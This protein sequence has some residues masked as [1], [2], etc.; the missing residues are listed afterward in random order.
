MRLRHLI[1]CSLVLVFGGLW[2]GTAFAA[3]APQIQTLH[4]DD[5]IPDPYAN[6]GFAVQDH[7]VGTVRM[8]SFPDGRTRVT[9]NLHVTST[10]LQTGRSVDWFISLAFTTTEIEKAR[11]DETRILRLTSTFTGLNFRFSLPGSPSISAGRGEISSV[12]VFDADGN[13]IDFKA[14][15]ISTPHI[16]HFSDTICGVMFGTGNSI[17]GTIRDERTH[18][19]LPNIC[20]VV[21][22]SSGAPVGF[23]ISGSDGSYSA[24]GETTPLAGSYKLE[25]S[26]C[27]LR[28]I[29]LHEWYRDKA[30]SASADPVR[31]V[32][33]SDTR[34]IDANLARGGTISGTVVDAATG[35]PVFDLCVEI[36]D[37]A[38]FFYGG[39]L[40]ASDGSYTAGG[41]LRSGSYRVLFADC[42]RF[43]PAYQFEWYKDKP[44][45]AS[46][47]PVAVL[48]GKDTA[49][50]NARVSELGKITGVVR[51]ASTGQPIS[52]GGYLCVSAQQQDGQTLRVGIVIENGVYTIGGLSTGEYKVHFYDCGLHTYVGEWYDNKPDQASADVVHVSVGQTTT[53]I[54]ASLDVGGSI[55]GTVTDAATGL[56]LPDMCVRVDGLE[57]FTTTGWDGTYRF[58]GLGTGSYKVEFSDCYSGFYAPEWYDNKPDAASATPV[59]VSVGTDRT[60]IDAALGVG[61]VLHG[62]VTDEVT[63][64]PLGGICATLVGPAG[65]SPVATQTDV[66]GTFSMGG[67]GTGG[68][69]LV[70]QDC[71]GTGYAPEWYDDQPDVAS[72]TI[73]SVVAGEVIENVD[74]ALAVGGSITGTVTDEASSSPAEGI[75]VAVIG[76]FFGGEEVL[77]FAQTGVDGRYQITGLPTGSYK[78]GFSDCDAGRYLGEW[79]D[80]KPDP[81]TAD[82]V[83]VTAAHATEGIDAALTPVQ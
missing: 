22:D 28:Q 27:T 50:I 1:I 4:V 74:A 63:G 43:S 71:A 66:D 73:I 55:S 21:H 29:Y 14:T 20:V 26:D 9:E 34:R 68:Y 65:D 48:Q 47:D 52:A 33:G 39:D 3:G 37:S 56:A 67:L 46:A 32:A 42:D 53:G 17:S 23:A 15:D 81:T 16:P 70:F 38:G 78:L 30:S 60:G 49:G 25:F 82:P 45:L 51:D 58:G 40:T 59:N 11:H 18:K 64:A 2:S 13:L 44:D 36:F 75:C 76:G 62:T 54:D 19:A 35:E 41:G 61:A 31:V 24:R 77:G 57:S 80:D 83:A 69:K 6:C 79:Y 8:F 12:L 10:N 7:E 5:T 72:A